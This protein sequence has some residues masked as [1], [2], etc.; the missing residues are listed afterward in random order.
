LANKKLLAKNLT[1]MAKA[2][3]E[4]YDFFPQTWILPADAKSFKD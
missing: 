3:P 2:M 1:L 4:H